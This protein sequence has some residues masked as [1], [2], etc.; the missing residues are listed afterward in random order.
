MIGSNP[1]HRASCLPV[2]PPAARGIHTATQRHPHTNTD[3]GPVGQHECVLTRP[4]GTP[5]T[6]GTCSR[7]RAEDVVLFGDRRRLFGSSPG[8]TDSIVISVL[9]HHHRRT[10]NSRSGVNQARAHF[11]DQ[12]IQVSAQSI[13]CPFTWLYRSLISRGDK[14]VHF[15]HHNS[16]PHPTLPAR[17]TNREHS[18]TRHHRPLAPPA[19]AF[20]APYA[21]LPQASLPL[22]P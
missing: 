4:N 6:E 7:N 18:H 15:K 10:S 17:I 21:A 9:S 12:R 13:W 22:C 16:Y 19:S 14:T 11:R 8:P 5:L 20:P 3:G 2:L 1:T